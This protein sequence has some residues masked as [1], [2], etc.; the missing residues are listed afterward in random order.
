MSNKVF[1]V[2]LIFLFTFVGLPPLAQAN[3]PNDEN[4]RV[5]ETLNPSTEEPVE[6]E[7]SPS[8]PVPETEEGSMEEIIPEQN[9]FLIFA[10]MISALALVIVL[11][12]FLL[13]FISKRSQSF[14]SSK[15]LE[16]IGGVPVG[17]NKSVQL[18]KIGDRVLVV[19][20]GDSIQLLKEIEDK[21][22]V[23]AIMTHQQE[24]LEQFD[25]PIQKFSNWIQNKVNRNSS[26]QMNK[27]SKSLNDE[28]F[29]SLLENNLKEVSKSQKQ[30]RDVVKERDK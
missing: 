13:R 2:A 9:T 28:R 18:V 17:A 12:Y 4:R 22:E 6:D 3:T 27:G 26:E 20:V 19:G 29:K 11:I 25:Q 15:L 1:I 10:Q 30:L 24:Q 21:D 8:A 7:M 16:N 23:R 5:S 14:H